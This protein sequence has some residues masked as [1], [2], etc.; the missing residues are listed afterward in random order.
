M[1]PPSLSRILIT[2]IL[3]IGMPW[4]YCQLGVAACCQRDVER[5]ESRTNSCCSHCCSDEVIEHS[6]EVPPSS[7]PQHDGTPCA[8]GDSCDS[9]C[10]SAKIASAIAAFHVPCDTIG[11]ELPPAV[12]GDM[13]TLARDVVCRS[14]FAEWP[15]GRVR[16]CSSGRAVLLASSILRS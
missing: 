14:S 2:L 13:S 12:V 4:C 3:I 10:C 8:P 7:D 6:G 16:T 9:P 11:C 15:P 1:R 5:A